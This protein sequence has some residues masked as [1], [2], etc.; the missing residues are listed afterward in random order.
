MDGRLI[1]SNTYRYGDPVNVP[2]TPER[3]EH[4]SNAFVFQ[5]WGPGFKD[6]CYGNVTYTAI[7][8][9]EVLRGDMNCDGLVN[10]KDV[11]YLLWHTKTP[12]RYPLYQKGDVNGDGLVD[13]G[14]V[15]YLLRY[16]L[17]PDK[18]TLH[19]NA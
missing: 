12:D 2:K 13:D 15:L 17:F 11:G 7:F 18:F 3:P 19:F 4:L 9:E 6:V 5:G 14:D 8:A 16:T 10:D 1:S